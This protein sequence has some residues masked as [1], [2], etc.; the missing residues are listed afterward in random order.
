MAGFLLG[1]TRYG[2]F[3]PGEMLGFLGEPCIRSVS[4]VSS[5]SY[6][7][8]GFCGPFRVQ[9]LAP[10]SHYQNFKCPRN[11]TARYL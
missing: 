3:G 5:E 7:K 10:S 4:L 6:V 2:G 11:L 9:R 1:S 8:S